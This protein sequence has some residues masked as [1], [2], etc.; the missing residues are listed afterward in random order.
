MYKIDLGNGNI[1]DN[2]ILNGTD[3]V[4]DEEITA[5]MFDNMGKVTITDENDNVTEHEHMELIHCGQFEDGYHFSL[6]E[7]TAQELKEASR[8]A[9]IMYTALL[10]D[11]LM[12]E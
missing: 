1:L 10:T 12:E 3:F 2:L 8:D 4:R 9:Q 5:D 7:V 11:T 6:H